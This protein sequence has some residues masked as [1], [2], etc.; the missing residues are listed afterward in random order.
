MPPSCSRPV[1]ANET[2]HLAGVNHVVEH[3]VLHGPGSRVT[4]LFNGRVDPVMTM[5]WAQGSDEQVA[6]FLAS[7][8]RGLGDLPVDRLADEL[9]V[10][11]I[12]A[13][14]PGSPSNLGFDLAHRFGPHGAGIANYPEYGL[15]IITPD[16]VADWART[17]FGASN[18]VLWFSGP[19]PPGLRLP[20][21]PRTPRPETAP[22]PP[23]LTHGRSFTAVD[24]S[25]V[26]LSCVYRGWSGV[27]TAMYLARQRV[28]EELRRDA[29]S[30]GVGYDRLFI[31]A[32]HALAHVAAD[33][34]DGAHARVAR[35]LVD[36]LDEFADSGPRPEEVEA[37]REFRRQFREGPEHRLGTLESAARQQLFDGESVLP[38]DVDAH[39]DAQ[40]VVSIRDD[41]RD[42]M[43]SL[44]LVGPDGVDAELEGWTELTEWSTDWCPGTDFVPIPGP[45][46]RSAHGRR[47][48]HDVD[49][50][51]RPVAHDPVVRRGG[52][53]RGRQRRP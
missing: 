5:F 33:A 3:L 29:L 36:V 40:T 9:R 23:L 21:L 45:R 25:R 12:E 30:Y 50:R 48:W 8:A 6:E 35:T 13:E 51:S 32:G 46:T 31:G 10:L 11:E 19:V 7:V 34:A 15:R 1:V 39:L 22:L 27:N 44:L 4:H 52:G 47:R 18:A 24:T 26:S 28:Y 20:G 37:F 42:A 53:A 17:R 49:R 2:L 38:D 14:Q 41:L 43:P 16:V